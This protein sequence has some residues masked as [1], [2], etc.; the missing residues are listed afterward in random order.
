[1]RIIDKSR[2]PKMPSK[3]G[4]G[5]GG[6]PP[7]GAPPDP[8]PITPTG[9]TPGEPGEFTPEG[10]E[11]PATIGELRDLNLYVTEIDDA[12]ATGEYVVI[13]SGNVH[14]NGIDWAMGIAE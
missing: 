9:V 7:Y 3:L 2:P 6:N 1:M 10:A 4:P 12:W 13:G 11:V 14:W 8:G 5:L